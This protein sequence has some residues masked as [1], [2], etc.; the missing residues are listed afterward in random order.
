MEHFIVETRNSTFGVQ[1]M[2]S[3]NICGQAFP[4][5]K[6]HPQFLT[7]LATGFF[8]RFADVGND[9]ELALGFSRHTGIATM[10]YQP[11]VGVIKKLFRNDLH[12]DCFHIIW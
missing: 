6:S 2:L 11:V 5:P 7:L 12:Q 8:F 9:A 3:P 10:Q 1:Q 4:A